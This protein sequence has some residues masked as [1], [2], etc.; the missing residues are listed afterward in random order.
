MLFTALMAVSVSGSS[1]VRKMRKIADRSPT[2][3]QRMAIGIQA[4][5]EIGLKICTSG[6]IAISTRR[7]QPIANPH[8]IPIATASMKPHV[9]RNSEA[10]TYF[11]SSPL[12]ASSTMPAATA[13]G[14]GRRWAGCRA[15]AKCQ[16][17]SRTAINA[18]GLAQ[19]GILAAVI[20]N[21]S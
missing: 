5:G 21:S 16:S 6:S 12:R 19:E 3:N 2:P 18:T 14:V 20:G 1:E 15:T 9:T 8:G 4:S 11:S 17:T 13:N 10:T 7:Y